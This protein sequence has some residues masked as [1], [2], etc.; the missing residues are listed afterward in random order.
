M[1]GQVKRI[2]LN[3]S[4]FFN[5]NFQVYKDKT[6]QKAVDSG[7]KKV[8]AE[9]SVAATGWV[10]QVPV[11][12]KDDVTGL[13]WDDTEEHL[14]GFVQRYD[15][16]GAPVFEERSLNKDGSLVFDGNNPKH[17]ADFEIWQLHPEM[18]IN[19][20]VD[21]VDGRP[22]VRRNWRFFV[23]N[24]DEVASP[25]VDR[26]EE[27]YKAMTLINSVKLEDTAI[28]MGTGKY[29]RSFC[30]M[31][32]LIE[33]AAFKGAKQ[34]LIALLKNPTGPSQIT[35]LFK[36]LA[37]VKEL[38][39]LVKNIDAGQILFF[40]NKIQR[41][42]GHVLAEIKAPVT[43]DVIDKATHLLGMYPGKREWTK[44]LSEWMRLPQEGKAPLP[45]K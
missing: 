14:V 6:S 27:D 35:R 17:R 5:V 33:A 43:G 29:G 26:F 45:K 4:E 22:Y 16:N 2:L 12:R 21:Q 3:P 24:V 42:D 7:K 31:P 13:T 23:E 28:L 18:K 1:P 11:K 41:I 37:A 10:I 30:N 25:T 15:A 39:L 36:D 20:L 34:H 19:P 44:D 8:C 38:D 9:H 40:D 32:Q